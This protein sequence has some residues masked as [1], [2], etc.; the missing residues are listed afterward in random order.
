[1]LVCLREGR[2]GLQHAFQI[3]D[4][5]DNVSLALHAVGRVQDVCAVVGAA[6]MEETHGHFQGLLLDIHQLIL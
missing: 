3:L 5:S 6:L 1:M 2:I 4:G